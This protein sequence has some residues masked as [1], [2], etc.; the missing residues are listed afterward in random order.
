MKCLVC[1]H[2]HGGQGGCS[3][4][5]AL[6]GCAEPKCL[7]CAGARLTLAGAF[8]VSKARYAKGMMLVRPVNDGTGTKTRSARLCVALRA[9]WTNRERGYVMSL[10]KVE[11]LRDLVSD[12]ADARLVFDSVH[13]THYEIESR[14]EP[15]A[16]RDY[17]Y[18]E[19][20]PKDERTRR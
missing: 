3:T 13:R 5:M 6:N 4:M 2:F 10:A 20:T 18:A 1:G 11:K 7:L 16:N 17:S 19:C 8:T 9:R 12:G 15:S 14:R